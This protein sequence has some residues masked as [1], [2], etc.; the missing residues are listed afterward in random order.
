MGLPPG[1]RHV[2]LLVTL[3]PALAAAPL[4]VPGPGAADPPAAR[5][6]DP[7]QEW[8]RLRQEAAHLRA[9]G[10]LAEAITATE[11]VLAIERKVLGPVHAGVAQT[12][13]QLAE[14]HQEREDFVKARAAWQEVL[15]V[16]LKLYPRDHYWVLDVQVDIANV[17]ELARLSADQRR[18][19]READR[20]HRRLIRLRKEGRREEARECG[21]KALAIRRRLLRAHH[22]EIAKLLAQLGY[23]HEDQGHHAA[24]QVY[25]EQAL[26]IFRKAPGKNHPVTARLADTLGCSF[27]HQGNY[28]TA[29]P[30]LE[31]ALSLRRKALG[32]DA[33]ETVDSLNNLGWLSKAQGDY[34]AAS[35]YYRRALELRRKEGNAP[36]I[37]EALNNLGAVLHAQGDYPAARTCFEQALALYKKQPAQYH[38]ALSASLNNLGVLLQDQGKLPAA[39]PYLEEVLATRRKWLGKS[40]PDTAL[41]HNNLGALLHLQGDFTGARRHLESALAIYRKCR[42][43]AHPANARAQTN[44]GLLLLARQDYPAARVACERALATQVKL[45]R[46]LLG[47]LSEVEALAYVEST[48]SGRDPLLSVLRKLPDRA[49]QAYAAVWDT[50]ALATR[51]LSQRRNLAGADPR[52]QELWQQ[53]RSTRA[54]LARLTLAAVPPEKA[55]AHQEL[56]ARV[57]AQKEKEERALADASRVFRRQQ[58]TQQVPFTD[59][60][61][62]L[63]RGVAVID[64]VQTVL[65]EP[66]PA[67][68]GRLQVTV[69]YEGFV[70]RHREKA[71]AYSLSW[72]HLGRAEPIERAVRAWRKALQDT[73]R[74]PRATAPEAPEQTLR[75]L[76]WEPLERHLTGCSAV[77][78]IPD[79][80]L[81]RVPWAALPGKKPGTYLLEEYAVGTVSHGQHLHELWTRKPARGDKA[82]LVGGVRYDKAPPRQASGPHRG[83]A[84]AENAR[85]SWAYLQGSLAEAEGIAQLWPGPRRVV[86]KGE[87]AGEAAL[88]AHLP[89]A[90]YIHL[91]THGF[92]ADPRFRGAFQAADR[93]SGTRGLLARPGGRSGVLGRNPLLLSGV[94][95][96]GANLPPP[97]NE[98]G[99]PVGDDGIL[100]AEEVADLDLGGAELVVLSACDT[101]LG[102][103]AGGEGVFGL[104]RAFALAGARTVVASLWKVDDEA[105]RELMTR[106]YEN[107]WHKRLGTLQAMRQAQLSILRGQPVTSVPRELGPAEPASPGTKK[108]RA[109]P[110]LWAAWVLSGDPGDLTPPAEEPSGPAPPAAVAGASETTWVYFLLGGGLVV[111]AGGAGWKILRGRRRA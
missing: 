65:W 98:W 91:A 100:T 55:E 11:K 23:L 17:D 69:Q 29:R 13:E 93:E 103:V 28:A 88:R 34:A 66:S 85:P 78:V 16:L 49:D 1:Q 87:E 57:T 14:L 46:D 50:R 8:K 76:V 77:L 4:A 109:H 9:K 79:G 41:A 24:A 53:L 61:A 101:G 36:D 42:I 102:E 75:R 62:R 47:S 95:L 32:K 72:L 25:Y 7:L 22:P 90:R 52:A 71:P 59:L 73:E 68:P 30:Y 105:T 110:W 31:Q 80:A 35:S 37:A 97:T 107:L 84:R 60:A 48:Q 83:P 20:L 64:L 26:A 40:H 94:V 63:P 5:E 58:Q 104:Q 27:L 99:A 54:K 92:F 43:E 70:L 51:A 82:L 81:T 89:G 86:L 21:E 67:S 15:A 6:P 3:L 19:L 108:A 38:A 2:R 18:Q 33:P 44:L 39:C 45:A 111:L 12:L 96:A 74:G 106:F 56:L 10:K